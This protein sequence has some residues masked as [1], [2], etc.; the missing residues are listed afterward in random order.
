MPHEET[1]ADESKEVPS[2]SFHAARLHTWAFQ[3][4]PEDSCVFLQ[5]WNIPEGLKN[6]FPACLAVN[7]VALHV[8]REAQLGIPAGNH[9]GLLGSQSR[10]LMLAED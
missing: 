3:G 10:S 6:H 5:W 9:K 4:M 1:T 8:P 7:A 2:G